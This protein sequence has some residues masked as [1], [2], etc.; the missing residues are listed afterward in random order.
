M[1]SDLSD[2]QPVLEVK[3]LAITY[4]TR[5]RDVPAV[6]GVTFNVHQ[7]E[8]VGVVENPDAAKAPLLSAFWI[9]Y[10]KTVK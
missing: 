1:E 6:R 3:D 2:Q 10:G 7:G 8:T 9:F 5:K 4:K